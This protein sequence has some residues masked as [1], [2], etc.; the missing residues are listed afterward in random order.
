MKKLF[1][2]LLAM[3]ALGIASS[4]E[5]IGGESNIGPLQNAIKFYSGCDMTVYNG[6]RMGV[7]Y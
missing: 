3:I 4:C 6:E 2:T 5:N 1:Y 7:M